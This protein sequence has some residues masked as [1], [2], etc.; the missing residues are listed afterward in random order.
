ME[1]FAV[2]ATPD[3]GWLAVSQP[4]AANS[5]KVD[6]VGPITWQRIEF[7]F[8]GQA[9]CLIRIVSVYC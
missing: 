1:S 3:G 6:Q 9:P 4:M 8:E 5:S 7:P 2:G